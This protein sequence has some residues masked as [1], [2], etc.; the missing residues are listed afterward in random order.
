[1]KRLYV[2]VAVF[3]LSLTLGVTA[4]A[5]AKRGHKTAQKAGCSSCDKSCATPEQ[6]KKFKAD[7][8]DLRRNRSNRSN[9]SEFPPW[10]PLLLF[11][12]SGFSCCRLFL[13]AGGAVLRC[14]WFFLFLFLFRRLLRLRDFRGGHR[15]LLGAKPRVSSSR[16]V[17]PSEG[18]AGVAAS[19]RKS[20][21][22]RR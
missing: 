7:S 12:R 9:R 10:R 1:M 8:I 15:P 19:S 22:R 18:N 20:S 4:M 17:C 16:S 21:W 3:A 2:A 14:F 5:Q 13:F 6:M 11:F